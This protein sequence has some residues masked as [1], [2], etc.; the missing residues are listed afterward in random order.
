MFNNRAF[1]L[2]EVMISYI[3]IFIL[4][5]VLLLTL[6]TFIDVH[7]SDDIY[8]ISVKK[9]LQYELALAT[10]ILCHNDILYYKNNLGKEK[11]IYLDNNRLVRG[12]SGFEIIVSEVSEFHCTDYYISFKNSKNKYEITY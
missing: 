6:S 7:E 10:N 5:N 9:Q 11:Q 2:F 12:G 3:I 4:I 1:T 8:V